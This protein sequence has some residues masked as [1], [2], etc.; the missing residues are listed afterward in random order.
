MPVIRTVC[1]ISPLWMALGIGFSIPS[2]VAQSELV[3]GE[4]IAH[5]RSIEFSFGPMMTSHVGAYDRYIAPELAS[6]WRAL[7]GGG[8]GSGSGSTG[9]GGF[10]ASA[11]FPNGRIPKNLS[12]RYS[13]RTGFDFS[14][15]MRTNLS[16]A[17]RQRPVRFV[18]HVMAGDNGVDFF[19]PHGVGV[20]V[21]P[22]RLDARALF[23]GA[24]GEVSIPVLEWGEGGGNKL[25]LGGGAIAYRSITSLDVKSAF[26]DIHAR[27]VQDR[28]E[29]LMSVKY[30][31]APFR[32]LLLDPAGRSDLS[33]DAI[34]FRTQYLWTVGFKAS[35]TTKF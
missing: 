7:W 21:D 35:I 8:G 5:D 9:N 31:S 12:Y 4:A 22:A 32:G 20:F 13:G 25:W 16:F 30:E 34:A 14:V 11:L 2:A 29:P 17:G 3:R 1:A 18:A 10:N 15:G 24:A 28:L 33:I 23:F 19:A 26:F 27:D 6:A